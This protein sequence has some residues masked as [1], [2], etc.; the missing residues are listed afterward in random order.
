M[1]LNIYDKNEVVKTFECENY[2]LKFGV[3]EDVIELFDFEDLKSS[4]DI[5]LIKIVGRVIPKSLGSIKDLMKDIF[6]GLTDEDLKNTTIKELA[7]VLTEVVKYALNQISEG[8][9]QK[10]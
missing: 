7:G 6:N 9:N 1:K 2:D 3:V 4:S 10:K 5:E 8:I